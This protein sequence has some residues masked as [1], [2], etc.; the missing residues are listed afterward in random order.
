MQLDRNQLIGIFLLFGIFYLW[1]IL[2]RPSPEEVAE[3]QRIQDSISQAQLAEAGADTSTVLIESDTGTAAPIPVVSD[4]VRALQQVQRLGAFGSA[5]QGDQ[6]DFVLENDLVRVTISNKGGMIRDVELKEYD[7]ILLDDEKEEYKV[8]V[9]LLNKEDNIF[10]YH[11]PLPGASGGIVRTSELYFDAQQSGNTLTLTARGA[12][13]LAFIQKYALEDDSYIVDYDIAI[14]GAD[15]LDRSED[16][17]LRWVNH[18]DKIEKNYQYEKYYTTVYYREIDEDP[19]YCSCRRD[20][21]DDLQ[22]RPLKWISHSNQFFNTSLIADERFEGGVLQ[23]QMLDDESDDLKILRTNITLPLEGN[24][25]EQIG[26]TMY[27][28]PNEFSRLRAFG[29]SLEDIIPFGRSIFG[30]INRWVIRPIFNVLSGIMSVKGIVIL[31]LTFLVKVVLF[32]LMYRMLYSQAKMSALKPQLAGLKDKFKDDSQKQQMETMKVYREYGVSPL[33]GCLPMLAQ[34]P[35]WFAL[36]RFF[37]AA[38]E[39][40]QADFLW[41]TDL[42]SY[43]VFAHLPFTIPFYGDHVSLFTLLWAITTVIYTYYN[44]RH[45]DMASMN[46]MMKYMQYFMPIMFL[47]FF[48]NYASGLTLYLFYSNV[49]NIGM[50]IGTKKFLFDDE[51]IKAELMAN[52]AKP[53]KKGGFQARLEQ[54]MK[55]QQKAAQQKQAQ[56]KKKRR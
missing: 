14:E 16:L 48:N 26:M 47:F 30:T 12:N 13:G 23:T 5:A 21:T 6:Q 42:S 37:P 44:T 31:L 52:K 35:I 34:M 17:K 32:P 56:N 3:R 51:K 40:R 33:G 41:A 8:P 18:L 19:D 36:Y 45:M 15:Q 9:H 53:K 27:L 29:Q 55:E 7:K 2:N 4:S 54:A 28:G 46:P 49:I 11:L 43:D 24:R 1:T 38:I 25:T 50:T 20:D 39:F 10:E 22:S